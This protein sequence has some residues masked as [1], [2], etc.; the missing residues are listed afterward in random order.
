[1]AS[2]LKPRRYKDHR[3]YSFPHT[4]GNTTSL[5]AIDLDAG[6]TNPNQNIPDPVFGNPAYPNGCT[7]FTTT[8][9]A[10]DEDKVVYNP[11]FTYTQTLLIANEPMGSACTLQD[12][13][14]SSIVYGLEQKGENAEQALWH[15]RGSYFEVH[16]VFGQDYF[17]SLWSAMCLKQKSISVGTPWFPELTNAVGG[18]VDDIQIRPTDDWHNWKACG[19]KIINGQPHLKV[20]AWT[21]LKLGDNGF[22]YFSR[23]T[24]NDLMAVKG[25]DA[26]MTQKASPANAQNV[27]LS[28]FEVLVSYYYRLLGLLA[29]APEASQVPQN[30]PVSV[31]I[32]K[33]IEIIMP[34]NIDTLLPWNTISSLSH[35]NWHNVRV[36]C[37]LEGLTSTMKE[38]LCATVWGESEFNTHARLDNKDKN[39]R[40]WSIDA[41][42]CQW[43]SYWHSKEISTEE[44]FND[45]EKAVRLM[46]KYFLNGQASDWVAY[47]SGRYLQFVGRKL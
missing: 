36:L 19:V 17:D 13:V 21:G 30:A 34:P 35:E 25:T 40:V 3:R 9:I 33:P 24:V 43:N 31:P 23:G 26:L 37:D 42:I 7:A 47:K 6:L 32:T 8:D 10:T 45:P 1:M 4:F 12:S 39:G 2:G 14:K 22:Y 11:G 44:A 46:C 18:I 20:K 5:F 41:G 27:R 15:R 28:V 29:K 16:P 38:E